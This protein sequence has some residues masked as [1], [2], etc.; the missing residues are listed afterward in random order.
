MKAGAVPQVVEDWS[1]IRNLWKMRPDHQ[2]NPKN[3]GDYLTMREKLELFPRIAR[4]YGIGAVLELYRTRSR[5]TRYLRDGYL[6]YV[7]IVASRK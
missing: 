7:L 1:G 3:P 5:A 2:W 6:G 4:Q